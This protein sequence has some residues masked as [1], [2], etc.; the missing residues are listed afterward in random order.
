MPIEETVKQGQD[1]LQ[2]K[3]SQLSKTLF[4]STF[5]LSRKPS[6]GINAMQQ[7]EGKIRMQF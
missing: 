7:S 2:T 6:S 5:R 1:L 4:Y 3:H